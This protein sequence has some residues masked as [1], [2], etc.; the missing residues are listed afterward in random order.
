MDVITLLKKL[1]ASEESERKLGNLEMAEAFA[2]KAQELLF[3]HKLDMSDLE[4]AEEEA[5]EPIADEVMSAAEIFNISANRSQNWLGILLNGICIPNFCKVIRTR[6][7]VFTVVGRKSDRTAVMTLFV[8]LSKACVEMAPREAATLCGPYG[9]RSGFVS[10]FK[11][12]FASAICERLRVKVAEL[13]AGAG[14]QGL[15]RINQMERAVNQ[16]YRE[17]FPNTRSGGRA[18]AR[19]YSGYSAGKAYGHSVGINSTLRL[20]R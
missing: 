2:T 4:I 6:P 3:K 20:G 9:D 10:S 8:Y 14:E 5:N 7:N 17:L 16:K 12:G 18:H 19:N 1:I 13:R 11:L 15:M